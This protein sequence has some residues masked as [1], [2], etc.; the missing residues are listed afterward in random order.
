MD[1]REK[2]AELVELKGLV[3][4]LEDEV[5]ATK[6]E[7]EVI[8]NDIELEMLNS[9]SS[10]HTF[11]GVATISMSIQNF[12][13]VADED[14]FFEYLRSTDQAGLI[15]QTVNANT[16]KSWFKEQEFETDEEIAQLGL[17]N[18]KKPKLNVR[19]L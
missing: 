17:S 5:K 6:A 7:I 19:S 11:P 1:L 15:K 3:K 4:N 14:V 12:P 16:L 18:Y 10:K 8:E 9:G 13:R 2:V